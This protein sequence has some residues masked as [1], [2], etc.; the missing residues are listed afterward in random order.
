[1]K[2]DKKIFAKNSAWTFDKNV[3][4][5]FDKHI[6]K[7]VPLYHQMQWLCEQVSDFYIKEDSVV[8]DIGCSTGNLL[9]K[10]ADRHKLK[11]K[12]KYIGLDVIK[13]MVNF[14]KKKSS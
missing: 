6:S 2:V 10:L 7:S 12:A 5:N 13:K 1:M 8:Y 14:A 9:F 11:K 4:K 3:P